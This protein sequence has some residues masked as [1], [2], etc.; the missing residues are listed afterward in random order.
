M[1]KCLASKLFLEQKKLFQSNKFFLEFYLSTADSDASI[2]KIVKTGDHAS[3]RI[4][5]LRKKYVERFE[6]YS[7]ICISRPKC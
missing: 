2:K 4:S 6:N 7:V 5:N 1:Q 3:A